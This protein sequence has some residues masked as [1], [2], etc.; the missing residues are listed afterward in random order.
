MKNL[1]TNVEMQSIENKLAYDTFEKEIYFDEI[2]QQYCVPL[3]FKGGFPPN[4]LPTNYNLTVKRNNQ[5][6][7]TLDMPKNH[8]M[9]KDLSDLCLNERELNFIEPVPS[10]QLDIQLGHFIPAVLVEKQSET[11]PLRRFL[12]V[13]PE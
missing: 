7:F 10:D 8:K 5:L 11:N 9:R 6:K 3:L 12:T 2:L 4:D 13:Q 1:A